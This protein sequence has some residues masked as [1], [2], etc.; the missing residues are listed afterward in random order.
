MHYNRKKKAFE[1]FIIRA[2]YSCRMRKSYIKNTYCIVV[3][4]Y[5]AVKCREK[6]MF[7]HC[8]PLFFSTQPRR[9]VNTPDRKNR[10]Q[11]RGSTSLLLLSANHSYPILMQGKA[12][13]TEHSTKSASRI[14]LP[15]VS[16]FFIASLPERLRFL[17]LFVFLAESFHGDFFHSLCLQRF[18]TIIRSCICNF[19]LLHPCL[20]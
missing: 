13:P 20:P 6:E 2:L 10:Y 8:K 19:I 18:I 12:L 9:N 1:P 11:Q 4:T 14:H 15:A 5:P 7:F 16:A 3:C 17:R